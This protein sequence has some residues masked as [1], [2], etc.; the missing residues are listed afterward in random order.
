MLKAEPNSGAAIIAPPE[1]GDLLI[2]L[3]DDQINNV[4]QLVL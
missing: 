2:L 1:I 4:M 3:D